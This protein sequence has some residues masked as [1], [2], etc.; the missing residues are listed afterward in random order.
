M[1]AVCHT[2]MVQHRVMVPKARR[3]SAWALLSRAPHG[4]PVRRGRGTGA[5]VALRFFVSKPGPTVWPFPGL[6]RVRS[7]RARCRLF[8][9]LGELG[10]GHPFR[11][12]SAKCLGDGTNVP[13]IFLGF[14]RCSLSARWPLTV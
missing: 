13:R 1:A 7:Q 14:F 12:Q 9:G 5:F 3:V 4:A 6:Y 10:P 2:L 11:K 8:L